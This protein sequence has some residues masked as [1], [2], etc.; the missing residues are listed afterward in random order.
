[1]KFV[2]SKKKFF[3][4]SADYPS[5]C[6]LTVLKYV[7][8]TVKV[9]FILPVTSALRRELSLEV[10]CISFHMCVFSC[11]VVSYSLQPHEL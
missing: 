1:M 7:T 4:N 9:L 6:D 3:S 5:P 10:W 2:C 8:E 11:S